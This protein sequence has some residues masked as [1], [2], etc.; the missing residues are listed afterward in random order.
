MISHFLFAHKDIGQS[1]VQL[2]RQMIDVII[3][4]SGYRLFIELV[5]RAPVTVPV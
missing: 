5:I 4:S 3:S 2:Q 1:I